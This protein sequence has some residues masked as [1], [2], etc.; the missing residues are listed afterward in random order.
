VPALAQT[1]PVVGQTM[2]GVLRASAG[3]LFGLMLGVPARPVFLAAFDGALALD[4]ASA[5]PIAAGMV[6]GSGQAAWS[7][8]VP[9][10][11]AFVGATIATQ[12]VAGSARL[13]LTNAA[14]ATIR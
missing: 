11:P 6:G 9:G 10:D 3:D 8:G 14:T 4:L 2:T 5:V 7:L 1:A 13:R 12:G